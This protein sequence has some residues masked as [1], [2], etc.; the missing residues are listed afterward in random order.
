MNYLK[1]KAYLKPIRKENEI[2]IW[3]LCNDTSINFG[4]PCGE[5]GCFG[6]YPCTGCGRIAGQKILASPDE[7]GLVYYGK[8]FFQ[9]DHTVSL[10]NGEIAEYMSPDLYQEISS[11]IGKDCLVFFSSENP[12]KVEGKIVLEFPS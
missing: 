9:H 3:T 8:D 1:K 6:K 10:G 4:R 7:L 12:L 11:G 2:Q 5:S